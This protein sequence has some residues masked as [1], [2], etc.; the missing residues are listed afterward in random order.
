MDVVVH[1]YISFLIDKTA[2]K[3]LTKASFMYLNS[4]DLV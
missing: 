2:L 3:Y 4:I 1:E